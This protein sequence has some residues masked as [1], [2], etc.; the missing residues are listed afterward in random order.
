MTDPARDRA[1]TLDE[2][3]ALED[4]SSVRHEYVAGAIY[5]MSGETR[6]H[7]RIALNVA[8]RLLATARGGPC[9]VSMEGVKL[10]IGN[11]V[12]YPDVMVAC[13]PEPADSRLEDAPCLVVEV[14]S[15]STRTT[16]Q[17]EKAVAYR[18]IPTLGAYLVVDHDRRA[19]ERHW[20]GE[21]GEWRRDTI[22][23]PGDVLLP[24]LGLTLTLDEIYEGIA[25]PPPGEPPCVR[26]DEAAY[27]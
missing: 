9:R 16:D 6:R 25:F 26:E 2:Y 22:V 8:A 4:A 20:R 13:R 24:C 27:A 10:R 17:R 18:T 23:E 19:V 5:A 15:P 11:V 14:L 3:F 1:L 21:G 7:N 12:Y